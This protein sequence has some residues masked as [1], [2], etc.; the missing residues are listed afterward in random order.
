MRKVLTICIPTYNME[1]LLPRCLDS[2]IIEKEFMERLE[3]IVVND[4]SKDSS[5]VIAHT[6]EN[7]YSNIYFVIDKNNG[8]YGSCVNAAL[9]HASGKYFRLV[10]A[11]DSVNPVGLIKLLEELSTVEDDIVFTKYTK[12]F[13]TNN[14]RL[15]C[16]VD[17]I[18]FNYA[19]N[20]NTE[21][22]PTNCLAMHGI[23]V[24]TNLLKS[25]NYQQTEGISYTDSEFV[26]YPLCQAGS[27]R[28]LDVEL[29]QYYLGRGEQTMSKSSLVKNYNNFNI[30]YTNFINLSPSNFNK[31]YYRL[32][33]IYIHRML[34][35]MLDVLIIYG[36]YTLE[37]DR[38]LRTY[39]SILE[40]TNR[41]AF[42]M[43]MS[44]SQYHLPYVNIW[45]RYRLLGKV[46]I[47]VI[48]ILKSR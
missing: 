11:D 3:I 33:N 15:S 38:Q 45:Y 31:N 35:Y 4:G 6:Y 19:Y 7:R 40:H 14:T 36:G 27:L 44:N 29:Y 42:V 30:L 48:Q 9:K 8:N 34:T 12:V 17:G 16:D 43:V 13:S 32:K 26:L 22:I 41:D 37:R 23:T 47:K 46:M 21:P 1:A 18:R 2:F 5:S 39:I 25:I 20:L 10:D 24:K 28:C